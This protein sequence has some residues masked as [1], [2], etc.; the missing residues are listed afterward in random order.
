MVDVTYDSRVTY[1]AA[2]IVLELIP[3]PVIL[4][5]NNTEFY[6][7]HHEQVYVELTG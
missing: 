2:P 1:S 5:L 3:A 6:Y 4:A 7:T